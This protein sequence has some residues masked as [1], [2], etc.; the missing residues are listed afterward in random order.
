MAYYTLFGEV[1]MDGIV[2][3]K[4]IGGFN[5]PATA[6]FFK[7]RC[8]CCGEETAKDVCL[9]LDE[10]PCPYHLSKVCYPTCA[11][12]DHMIRKCKQCGTLG[13]VSLVPGKG[14]DLTTGCKT[15]I[16]LIHCNGYTPSAFTP[17]SRWIATKVTGDESELNYSGEGFVSLDD[18]DGTSVT[19]AR[20][21]FEKLNKANKRPT[22]MSVSRT[23]R[24]DKSRSS[25]MVH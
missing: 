14:K 4:P 1:K 5:G 10:L 21:T 17:A 12:S 20:F 13:S 15:M 8:R 2:C 11:A 16:M 22:K 7:L 25:Q 24:K 9:F 23:K 6:Y 19:D 3:L 18:D